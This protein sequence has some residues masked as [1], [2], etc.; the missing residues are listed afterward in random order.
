MKDRTATFSVT[1]DATPEQVWPFV[2]D[3]G[4]MGEW[5]PKQYSVEWLSGEP[6]APGSTFRSTGWLPNDKA[7]Q[8][9]G[10]VTVN[11]PMKTFEVVSHD[12]N[13]E[14]TNRYDLSPSGSQTT[15]TKTAIGPPLTGI[16]KVARSAIFALYVNGA[17]QRG[18]DQ[19]KAKVESSSPPT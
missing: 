14:W 4:R 6:N 15:V 2:G 1:I 12:D 16:K 9:E 11:E 19:L 17:M 8:M 18:M 7:H 3:L 5:S 10:S 13:E